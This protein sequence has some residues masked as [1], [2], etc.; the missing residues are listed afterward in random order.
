[1]RQV[2]ARYAQAVLARDVDAFVALYAG[3]V[4][5]FDMWGPWTLRGADAW[6]AMATD[7]FDS[8]GDERVVVAVEDVGCTIL[9][10]LAFG[11]AILTYAAHAAHAADGTPLRALANRITL[12]LR[13]I[14]GDWKIVHE[15]SS[16]PIDHATMKAILHR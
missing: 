16:V 8:L 7:W 6:R 13:R 12:G 3:D 14:D 2:L 15:H 1:M 5:A 10:D 11:H 9:G 4:H